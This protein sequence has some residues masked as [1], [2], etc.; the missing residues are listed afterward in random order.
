[1]KS[2]L[3]PSLGARRMKDGFGH[4]TTWAMWAVAALLAVLA[5]V[6]P[7]HSPVSADDPSD[8]DAYNASVTIE[9]NEDSIEYETATAT[10]TVTGAHT[11]FDRSA[12]HVDNH[13][14]HPETWKVSY[15]TK[16]KATGVY[17]SQARKGGPG[18]TNGDFEFTATGTTG[19]YTAT[20][21]L[22]EYH[23]TN[24]PINSLWPGQTHVVEATLSY[25]KPNNRDVETATDEFD[26]KSDCVAHDKAATM[27]SWHSINPFSWHTVTR[28]TIILK[29]SV[30][31]SFAPVNSGRCL[32]YDID[33]GVT[34]ARRSAYVY[35]DGSGGRQ[36]WIIE[37]GLM[38]GTYYD[39]SV[40]PDPLFSA[41]SSGTG[42]HTLGP[43]LI[44]E[45][46]DIEQTTA[47]VKVSLP[48]DERDH[49]ERNVHLVYYKT[50]DEQDPYQPTTQEEPPSQE[51]VGYT[52]TF[53]LSNLTAGTEYKLK[54]SLSSNFPTHQTERRAFATKPDKPTGLTVTPGN[55][56]LELSWTKP[57]GGDEIAEY[58]VQWKSGTQ[59]FQDATDDAI[60]DREAL[61]PHLSGTTTFDTTISGLTNGTE[62]TVHVIAKNESGQATSDT[63]TGTPDAL[64]DAPTVQ[65]VDAGNT[66]LTVAWDK[67]T[68][69]GSDIKGYVV[70][71]KDNSVSGWESPLGS[72]TLEE[73]D[74]THTITSLANET[75]YAIRVRAVNGLVL[76]DEDEDDYNWSDDGTG[77][78]R[79]EPIVT[80]VTVA[81]STVTQTEATAAVE[82]DNQTGDSQ[83]VH[84]RHRVNIAGSSWT[85][86]P[87]KT[88][89]AADTSVDF[90]L[91]GL[92]GNTE[93]VVEAWL[94][95]TPGTTVSTTFTTDPV[96]PGVPTNT[97]VKPGVETLK[98]E[99]DPPTENGG[100]TIDH[101]VIEWDEYDSQD[102]N[103]PL[104]DA[105]TTGET[106]DIPNLTNRTRY[107]VRIRADNLAPKLPGKSYNWVFG[108]GTPR[109]IPAEPTVTVTPDN[110][111][112][113]VSW[114]KPDNGGEE[115]S[116]F[117]VQYKKNADSA[118]I[119]HAANAGS[120]TLKTTIPDLDNGD[121]Y[122]VRVRAFNSATVPN[123]DD[124]KWGKD[125]GTPRTIPA[126]PTLR[127]TAG[128]TVLEVSWDEPDDGGDDITGH[129]VQYK[130][131]TDDTWDTS[132]A[133]IDKSTDAQTEI[134]SYKTTISNLD[135][136]ETYLV[137]VR[138]V[139]SVVLDD[140]K[141][142]KWGTG[143][144]KPKT[145]PAEPEVS[146]TPGNAQLEVNWN[147]PEDGGDTITE[148]VVQ[149]MK[150][151]DSGW[152][153]H[154]TPGPND[155]TKTITGLDNG[156]MYTVRVRAVNTAETDAGQEY[157]W[158]E[159]S[160]R[161]RTIPNKPDSVTVTHGDK[162]LTVTWEEPA[163]TLPNG[164]DTI[165]SYEIQWKE[166]DTPGW[167]SPSSGSVSATATLELVITEH[168]SQPLTNGTR[169][170]V[171]VKAVNA[172]APDAGQEYNWEYDEETPSKTPGAPQ[173]VRISDQGDGELTVEWSAPTETENGG[174]DISGYVV[175]W[176]V[177]G[178]GNWAATSTSEDDTISA[179]KFSHTFDR[180]LS[181]DLVNGM[182]YEV[183][184]IA[185]NRNGRGTPSVA[186]E[187]KPRTTPNAPDDLQVTEGKTELVLT[188]T[189]PTETGGINITIDYYFVEYKKKG[190]NSFT[191]EQTDDATEGWTLDGLDNGE[192]YIVQVKAHNS[193]GDTSEPSGTAT[194][195]PRTIP[196]KPT[197]AAVTA[198]NGTL[199]VTWTPPTDDGGADPTKYILEWE[200]WI[201]SSSSWQASGSDED[202]ASPF[203]KG[204]LTNGT[205][206]RVV[207]KAVNPAGTGPESDPM[208]G[209][210]KTIPDA[211]DVD[212]T[213][214]DGEFKVEWN[215]PDS[216]GDAITGFKV[217]YKKDTDE[218][219]TELSEFGA[220]V[221]RT[222]ITSLDNG[223]PYKVWVRAV[224]T[225]EP[226]AGPVYNWGKASDTPRTFPAAPSVS[227]KHGDE[228]LEVTWD[229]PDKRG[230][231]I[232][233][234][235][236]QY[237][238]AADTAWIGHS[239]PGPD[240]TTTT[241]I[242]L[243]NGVPYDVRVRA[244]NS[245]TL[246]DEDNYS[247]GKKSETPRTIPGPVTE[248]GVIL[249]DEELT[250]SWVAPTTENNGGAPIKR[251]VL[252]WKSGNE[253]YDPDSS[254]QTTTT[255]VSKVL[256]GLSN[257]ILYYIQ[258]RA[259]NDETAEKYNWV[260]EEGTPMSVPGAPTGL[261]VEEGDEQLVV[262]WVA[263]KETGGV[264][265]EIENF[266]IQW[267][268]KD[269]D[270]SS[271]DEHATTDGNK[272]TDTIEEL[273]NGTDY[274]IRVRADN[275]V[276][277]QTFEWAYTTGKP[278][279]IP[280]AP[281]SLNVTP[282][283]GQL[284]LS[285]A[286]PSETG[287][288][289]I[290][291]YV[292]QWKWGNLQYNNS[293]RQDT[294]PNRSYTIRG[295][296]NDDLHSVRVRADNTVI[297]A[298]E[299]S[300]NWAPETGTPV[301]TPS[302]PPP[303][304]PPPPQNNNPPQRSPVNPTPPVIKSPEVSDVTFADILQTSADAT[305]EIDN[306]GTSQKTV[307]LH[308]RIEGTTAW[309]TPPKIENTR[310][311]S[312]TFALSDLTAGTTYEVQAWLD[313][314]LPPAGTKIYEFD[315]LDELAPVPDAAIS[316][317][318]CENIGQTSATAMVEIAN[319]GTDMKQVFLKHS[320]QGED[321]WTMLPF[322]TITYD[323][324]TSIPLTGLTEGTTYEVAV[325]LSN[326][327]SGMVIGQCTTLLL[328]PVV[329]GI[330][331]DRRKQTSVWANVSIANANG[332]DQTVHLR[333]RTTTPQG[334]W[335]DIAKTTT[336]T[337]SAS[338]EIAGLTADTEY[339]VEASLD[340]TFPDELTKNATFTTLRFPSISN[341]KV[342][343]ET[344]SS[345]TAVITIADPDGSSQTIHLRYRTTI[346]QGEW[347]STPP[348]SST[349]SEA[350]I[351][352]TGLAPDTEYEVEVSLK[353]DFGVSETETF[354]T[355]PLDPVVSGINV[356]RRKQT[357]AWANI[358]IA[359]ANGE[360]QTVHL[361]YRTT[362]PRGDW[363]EDLKTTSDSETASKEISGLTAG[364]EYDVRAS[365]DDSFPSSRTKLATFTTL[366]WPSIASFEEESVGR[367]GATVS[368]TIADSHGA[369][370][371]VHVRHRAAG[372]IAWRPTQQVDSV[373]DVV[374]LRL[375]GLSSGTEYVAEASLDESFPS[376]ETRSVTFTTVKR[377]D[378]DDAS[379][380][381]SGTVQVARAEN[382]PLLGF[383]PQMLRF[384]AIEGGDNPASQTFSVW[385]RVQGAMSF[386]LSNHEEWLS[387]QP[388]SGVSNGP[389]DPVTI[390][391]S[392]DSVELASG[393]YVDV[394][395]IEVTSAG[396]SPGQ[397]IVV[398]DVLP[399]DYIRQF[400]SRDEG[401]VI[402]MPD[403]TV[404]LVVPPGSPPKDVDI[405][406]MK[407]NTEA[408]GEPLRDSERVVLALDSNTYSPGGDTP[409]DVA[410]SP[411]AELWLRLPSNDRT[412][413]DEGKTR[414]Y[415]VEAETWSLVE[416]RCETDESG[417]AWAVTQVERLG[418]FALV[419]DDAPVAATTTPVAAAVAPTPTAIPA[420]A[421]AVIVQRI[422]LPAQPPTPTPTQIPTPMPLPNGKRASVQ[423]IG[424]APTQTAVSAATESLAQTL[425]ASSEDGD[426]GSFGSIVLAAISAPLIIGL[427]IVGY[428][429]Y[430][431]RRRTCNPNL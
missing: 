134:T 38:P 264:D 339:E 107:A 9:V 389:D 68:N 116:G 172:A 3:P 97:A 270:W 336:S 48:E 170:E 157:N 320:I 199:T 315:T 323:D 257:G 73:T 53:T 262:S 80:D 206:Y 410:Y 83:T 263:P 181:Q 205:K 331:V 77:T 122:D 91:S 374:N 233:G 322:P 150:D 19:E 25:D 222:T 146:V 426:S 247:W 360:D 408:H 214:G 180:H 302:P 118:W 24:K 309:S 136:G 330:S 200:E 429:A 6:V 287:G 139:N 261:G 307:R 98:L 352:L 217:Q 306:V 405:E 289:N 335:G 414:V 396:K 266:V 258:V 163:G 364:T 293:D 55:E 165:T 76:P 59:T 96:P 350:S 185:K 308:Y 1:M 407:L 344:K 431:E 351:G 2:V 342:E 248:L 241:I 7:F 311:S 390:T 345:A 8:H 102:W 112:L 231:T 40:N 298:N 236:V 321:E 295:L 164:G 179:D 415:F 123:E 202:D 144:G 251:F 297:L 260:E 92:A 113:H 242:S 49:G 228:Q 348:G 229:K 279:T 195:K 366:R 246:D 403:G 291:R 278:R 203:E 94:A 417:H 171:R 108:D 346:P 13:P 57:A 132:N 271:P 313:S 310:G 186:V 226:D 20:V 372:Y 379:S 176:R 196:G 5:V 312:K 383:S 155:T 265:V 54:A 182:K 409:E 252:Q 305:V 412:A 99:W 276:E 259:D 382:I 105:T 394:I 402:T 401:G 128:N 386:N 373:D 51:T 325:A 93:H 47:K 361:R 210:P 197:I 35:N 238:K 244:V 194:G 39:F 249:G 147:K 274:D 187:G 254:R 245:V 314:S 398:L 85:D 273:E 232:T 50:A 174:D 318:K 145:I 100:A 115:I 250:L 367:N 329:S 90:D 32:W 14:N 395:N 399:P 225:A 381:G 393:Q 106:Y 127:V 288:L 369:V 119:T 177:K 198:G 159:A 41:G 151:T 109:T 78:P 17:T 62:Y 353:S 275:D 349:T 152:T 52:T 380:S 121:L 376:D 294:T 324:D 46:K 34:D 156:D 56:Q 421:P 71:W 400:V 23:D 61:V 428:L 72:S 227:L 43:R 430:R 208:E 31:Y 215:K 391:A 37:T 239:T 161:P 416:H 371:T 212:L 120:N 301:A 269:G 280:S 191:S 142:Y 333:Y 303:P 162:M 60:G 65:R 129:V 219:W 304:P 16:I 64:P 103:S 316:N 154:S 201:E 375:R 209:T 255:D 282:G 45:V 166:K 168:L 420:S 117:V 141:D 114:N 29:V 22:A 392:V 423:T 192:T 234:F 79:P 332:E 75:E 354:R 235:V 384:V 167:S 267:Q 149:Y 42:D 11:L 240:D 387:Q 418:A 26:T 58:I 286:A 424:P 173:R 18:V 70:Q 137:R 411:A 343:D 357:S 188:W 213:P 81:D 130:K 425:Q 184:V 28:D 327:F 148:F 292:V 356:D 422:S 169:Y 110:A 133:T 124:Y 126:E 74:F 365:L 328:D 272:L 143:S 385:N 338:K 368:A 89:A 44:I 340:S 268:V 290:N 183:H 358:S 160:D 256:K 27:G 317:L 419:I 285:W 334:E 397:V 63:V 10:I 230:A 88:S 377:K 66:K 363:I 319:A 15:N 69:T 221:L 87:T 135:N 211:P 95:E 283:D 362:T 21:D 218:K 193:E 189:A 224:N 111:R 413:C 253:E 355:L 84:L 12:G 406:L 220:A 36:A 175:Q 359:N 158:G 204:S 178:I 30:G 427:F 153:D 101:Y 138:A 388:M 284:T 140:E 243:D 4:Q 337:D 237:K 216:G 131:N 207:V 125:G 277:G 33:G 347:S 378:D 300:Y 86:E 190:E 296:T 404:R 341:L 299:E 223:D 326:D 67:P 281:R 370:Q 82:I 104:G